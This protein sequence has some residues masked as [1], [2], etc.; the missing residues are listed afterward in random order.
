MNPFDATRVAGPLSERRSRLD[1]DE[2]GAWHSAITPAP[3]PLV[4]H[5]RPIVADLVRSGSVGIAALV[6]ARSSGP[7]GPGAQL[8]S[9]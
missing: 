9:S 6:G 7:W 5:T 3:D 4:Q 8:A 2:L 1:V